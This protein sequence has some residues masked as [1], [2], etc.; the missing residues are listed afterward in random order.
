M[1]FDKICKK[2]L[3]AYQTEEYIHL[4]SKLSLPFFP[5]D[6][7]FSALSENQQPGKPL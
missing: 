5:F 1:L 6:E 3:P 2:E 4:R 7:C